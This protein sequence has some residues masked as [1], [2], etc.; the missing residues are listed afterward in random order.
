MHKPHKPHKPVKVT[1]TGGTR[2]ERVAASYHLAAALRQRYN[3]IRET[4]LHRVWFEL[5][6][7]HDPLLAMG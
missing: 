7:M 5:Y 1:I 6:S 4:S 2:S 3:W